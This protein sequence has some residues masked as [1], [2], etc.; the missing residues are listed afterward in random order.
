MTCVLEVLGWIACGM[1]AYGMTFAHFQRG[2]PSIAA[3]NRRQDVA[4]ATFLGLLG[5]VGLF[6]ALLHSG[7]GP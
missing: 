5:P 4:Y 2:Y 6:I 1:L 3:K 7:F